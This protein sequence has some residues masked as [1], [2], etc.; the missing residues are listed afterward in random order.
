M[1]STTR[2][3]NLDLSSAGLEGRPP[4]CPGV[5]AWRLLI[6][7]CLVLLAAWDWVACNGVLAAAEPSGG[8]PAASVA[9]VFQDKPDSLRV[10]SF[11]AAPD[12]LRLLIWEGHAPDAWIERCEK[13]ISDRHGR[14]VKLKVSYVK[15]GEYFYDAIRDRAVDVVMMTHHEY[16]DERFK[17]IQNG[18][19]LPLNLDHIPN[20]QHVIPAL[21]TNNYLLSRGEVYAV[22]VSQGPYGLAY[23]TALMENEPKSWKIFWDSRFKGQYVLGAHEFLYNVNITALALDYPRESIGSYDALNNPKFKEKLRALAVNAHSFWVGVDKPENLAG[24]PLAVSW[25]DSLGPLKARGEL[26]KIA[27]PAEGTMCW[28]DNYA[29]T[30]ALKD[31]KFLREVAEEYINELL[32]TDFQVGHILRHMSLTPTITNVVDLL[33]PEETSRL[34]LGGPNLP[35]KNRILQKTYS[36]RDRNGLKLLWDEATRGIALEGRSDEK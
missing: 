26:W 35:E 5:V 4:G 19:L 10:E 14:S 22:P 12:L 25:G 34:R 8:S 31:N 7:S 2:Y 3:R 6:Q 15:G 11:D 36:R 27:E 20:F 28:V 21:K 13:Q 32:T 24:R 16:K 30:W 23:N 29:I 1:I 33:T 9:K 18:L 17:Y